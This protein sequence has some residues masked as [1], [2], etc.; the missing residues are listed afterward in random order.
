MAS[1]K[2]SWQCRIGWHRW[3]KWGGEGVHPLH[4]I[5]RNIFGDVVLRNTPT[6]ARK[7]S[8]CGM[9]KYRTVG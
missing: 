8:C 9:I 2:T 3:E 1:V 5:Q 4:C 7:C 6:Q